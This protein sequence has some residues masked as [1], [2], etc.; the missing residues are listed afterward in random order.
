MASNA[1][2]GLPYDAVKSAADKLVADGKSVAQITYRDILAQTATGSLETI[3]IHLRR[4]RLEFVETVLED[5]VDP[6]ELDSLIGPIRE[7]VVRKVR[8]VNERRDLEQAGE[9]Q[10]AETQREDL[11][12]AVS[13]NA[14]LETEMSTLRD[15]AREL[16]EQ[17]AGTAARMA[18][19]Q[20]KLDEARARYDD[21]VVRLLPPAGA[22]T[23]AAEPLSDPLSP[24]SA[25][26]ATPATDLLG[27]LQRGEERGS[28]ED[29]RPDA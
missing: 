10:R 2:R 16:E 7:I 3:G 1:A 22:N 9:R 20:G 26:N 12:F 27:D 6:A 23:V 29:Y 17:I 18:G 19:L 21:L 15:R 5:D 11:A 4:Y 8:K 14:V 25:Q 13:Q 28:A 24:E